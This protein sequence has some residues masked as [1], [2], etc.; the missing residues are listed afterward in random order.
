LPEIESCY[1]IEEKEMPLVISHHLGDMIFETKIGKHK[2]INDVP[3][4]PEW[5]GKDRHPTPPDYFIASLSSCIAAFVIQYC[6]QARLDA[7]GMSV[8]IT[9]EKATQPSHM[10]DIAVTI[11]L[12][13]VN[14]GGRLE[15]IKRVCRRC[16]V[17]ETISK[18][19]AV[20][21]NVIDKSG[22]KL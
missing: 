8:E 21:I 13:E 5:G 19:G 2:I 11:N 17:H 22:T 12:P 7:S 14:L 9:Y 16:T 10:K 18:M 6:T 1:R 15:A 20:A 4:T 3:P